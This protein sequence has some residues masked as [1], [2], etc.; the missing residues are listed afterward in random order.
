MVN[1]YCMFLKEICIYVLFVNLYVYLLIEK[2]NVL[3]SVNS[4][5]CRNFDEVLMLLFD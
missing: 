1:G 2:C 4:K 5:N 3:F